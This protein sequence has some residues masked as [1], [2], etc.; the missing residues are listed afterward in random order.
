MALPASGGWVFL[1]AIQP[2]D[3]IHMSFYDQI[4]AILASDP[5]A[6]AIEFRGRWSTR[7]D[8]ALAARLLMAE[9]AARGLGPGG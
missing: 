8:L 6:R 7:R 9:L 2:N 5:D 1:D 4:D 3:V